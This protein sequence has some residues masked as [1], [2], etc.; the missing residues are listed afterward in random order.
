MRSVSG[1]YTDPTSTTSFVPRA[2][3]SRR[4]R[5]KALTIRLD[6]GEQPASIDLD[7]LARFGDLQSRDGR[8][9]RERRCFAR[10][11][12]G[13]ER[14]DALLEGV[15]D[16]ERLDRATDDDEESRV[17]LA[18]LENHLALLDRTALSHGSNSRELLRRQD[19]RQLL[20]GCCEREIENGSGHMCTG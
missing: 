10:E 18:D 13:S 20:R 9:S 7:Q 15:R 3:N 17:R 12:A 5:T 14:C 8:T 11:H 16:S 2:I 1:Q 6:Q 19:W 4:R